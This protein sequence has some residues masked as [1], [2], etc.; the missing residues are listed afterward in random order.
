MPFFYGHSFGIINPEYDPFNPDI[1][2]SSYDSETRRRSARVGQDYT[3]RKSYNFQNV[4]KERGAGKTAHF[5]D[6]SNWTAGYSY[7]E[8]LHRDFN[9]NYD[10]TKQWR[11]S[12]AYSYT[13]TTKPFEP[14]KKVK[15]LQKSPYK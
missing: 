6:I 13:F 12:L 1:K 8:N 10:R 7:S 15:S 5:F 9:T 2:L 14:F 11:G 4:R 3:E